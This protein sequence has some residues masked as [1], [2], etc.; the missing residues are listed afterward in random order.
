MTSFYDELLKD[1]ERLSRSLGGVPPAPSEKDKKILI[2]IEKLRVIDPFK[3][4]Y[5]V[6]ARIPLICGTPP[7]RIVVEVLEYQKTSFL[8]YWCFWHYLFRSFCARCIRMSASEQKMEEILF[9][10]YS[11][12]NSLKVSSKI[13]TLSSRLL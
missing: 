11:S 3:S 13:S 7:G 6:K 2:K 4:S 12:V 10:L 8:I 9:S 5:G 1:F